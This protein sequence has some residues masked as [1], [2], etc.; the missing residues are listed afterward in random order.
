[1]SKDISN[2]EMP[3]QFVKI[4]NDFLTDILNTF[5]E[6]KD[7]LS[8]C[9]ISILNNDL[10]NNDLFEY[11]CAIYPSRFFD[12]LY[13]NEEMFTDPNINTC[14]LPDMDFKHFFD[15]NITEKTKETI[16][17]YLQIVLF[18]VSNKL[19][20]ADSF[21]D[22]AK[23]FEAIDEDELKTKM[24]DTMKEMMDMFDL[25]KNNMNF[26]N[27]DFSNNN[28]KDIPMP[29]PE[30]L[31][32]HIN[33][34]LNG[35][36]GCLAGEIAKETAEELDIDMNNA[37][38]VKDVFEKLFKNPGKLLNMV[39]KVGKKLDEKL[40]SGEI[41]ESEL[42]EE[43]SELM[44]KMKSMP[45]V[46]NMEQI[47]SKMGMPTGKNSKMNMNAM[48]ANL[49]RNIKLSKQKER[50]REKLK[51]R[52]EKKFVHK[53]Y[54]PNCEVV[55]KSTIKP[56]SDLMEENKPKKRK[57]RKKKKKKKKGNAE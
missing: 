43:A 28:F 19:T 31:N 11:C 4:M 10:S 20:E 50:L 40:K 29:N 8:D 55:Q 3:E 23:L 32:E 52:Q 26:D 39:K 56:P 45:G 22:T 5:P 36:L 34:L 1:M 35:K 30:E 42:M 47:F 12:I 41:K 46:K 18:T 57:K 7:N 44:K 2:V 27:V 15:E 25:S 24:E 6:Y 38:D 54:N 49:H 14:F 51:K 21:G 37:K 13:K 17:K 48:Q 9:E 16:W 53:K 33:E